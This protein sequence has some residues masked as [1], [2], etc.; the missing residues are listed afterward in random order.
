M[1][2]I[3][4]GFT[5][6]WAQN[7]E[8]T[9]HRHSKTESFPV[10]YFTMDMLDR[11]DSLNYLDTGINKDEIYHP[12]Y[13][14][15][16]IFQDLGNLITPARS[17]VFN[18]I[19]P[20]GFQVGANPFSI[21]YKKPEETQYYNTKLPYADFEYAQ[22]TNEVF[23]LNARYAQNI[24]PRS[25][26]GADYYG[27]TSK[28]N[29][30]RQ[31]TNTY[32]TRLYYYYTNKTGN[33]RLLSNAVFN[34]GVVDESGGIRSDSAFE[35]LSGS[36]KT[37]SVWLNNTE[38]RFKQ[39]CYTVKQYYLLGEKRMIY[40]E[41][42]T[43][44]SFTPK[45]YFAHTFQYQN[46]SQI[47]KSVGDTSKFIFPTYLGDTVYDIS[48]TGVSQFKRL[49]ST[50]M[51][52]I[53]NRI[54]YVI[55]GGNSYS[56]RRLLELYGEHQYVQIAQVPGNLNNTY[57]QVQLGG[58]MYQSQATSY[59]P[60]FVVEA[61]YFLP[62]GY[63][64]NDY[65]L[66]AR[67]D[68]LKGPLS[69]YGEFINQ[70]Y[71]A[72]YAFKHF[73]SYTFEWDRSFNKINTSMI[74]AGLIAQH[75]HL[76]FALDYTQQI[77]NNYVFMNQVN[78][79]EQLNKLLLVHRIH[80]KANFNWW[81]FYFNHELFFQ[82]SSNTALRLPDFGGMIRYYFQAPIFKKQLLM[83]IGIDAFY[84]SAYYAN[85]YH[86]ETR[87]FY[88]QDL[89]ISG[90]YPLLN[91][92]ALLSLRKAIIFYTFE[93]FNQDWSKQGFYYTPHY[94]IPLSVNRV[95]LRWRIFN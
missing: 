84:N 28:G 86:P 93:H 30:L 87:T 2:L 90:N 13:R 10:R 47:F 6:L 15:N 24:S 71:E 27:P 70:W 80:L 60:G 65:K 74:Q 95:G 41:S 8:Q 29:Y 5:P 44:I 94:P 12:L 18:G 43:S 45:S 9:N 36:N 31:F 52:S 57:Q 51:S 73:H 3:V 82:N 59:L 17:L 63:N 92:F 14:N 72:A 35:A 26:F 7:D 49:D 67:L 69:F 53:N 81:K 79:P 62:I 34:Y 85:A 19:S 58:S 39:N 11:N 61:Y 55:L 48:T 68:Y 64:A 56:N 54:Q 33:Y 66:R 46:N 88:N 20:S 4:C 77:I 50:Y 37:A 42:D 21:Y 38:N 22:G 89:T 91:A 25:G 32:H 83:Q 78:E 23:L 75:K 16:I 40:T 1:A 76:Q